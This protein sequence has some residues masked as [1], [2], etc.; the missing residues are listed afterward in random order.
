M[1]VRKWLNFKG[2]FDFFFTS[3]TVSNKTAKI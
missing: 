2:K 3:S 1:N